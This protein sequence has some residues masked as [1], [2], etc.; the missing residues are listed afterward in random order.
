MMEVIWKSILIFI[1]L[2]SELIC[3]VAVLAIKEIR[4]TSFSM[5]WMSFILWWWSFFLPRFSAKCLRN[6][7]N[8]H[9]VLN[10]RTGQLHDHCSVNCMRMDR[11]DTVVQGEGEANDE[12]WCAAIKQ[13]SENIF[14][15]I[16]IIHKGWYHSRLSHVF[17]SLHFSFITYQH[18][19]PFFQLQTNL[20]RSSSS[21]PAISWTCCELSRCPDFSF[22][23]KL[24]HWIL[25]AE[26]GAL[27]SPFCYVMDNAL[28][29]RQWWR[30]IKSSKCCLTS[31]SSGLYYSFM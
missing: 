3:R 27:N 14:K 8:R 29:K 12:G 10:Q 9:R 2:F 23:E 15:K 30:E 19:G 1:W 21:S 6:G 7:C 31:K 22:S 28:L 18:F 11:G 5:E 25:A 26:R 24:D 16:T 4:S 20:V 13:G 17:F